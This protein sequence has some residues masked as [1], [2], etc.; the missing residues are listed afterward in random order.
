[1]IPE[2]PI[3]PIDTVDIG[4]H[5][6]E[7]P[8]RLQYPANLIH[9]IGKIL[10]SRQMFKKVAGEYDIQTFLPNTPVICRSLLNPLNTRFQAF[11]GGRIEVQCEFFGSLDIINKF[12][13]TTAEV[14]HPPTFRNIILKKW[15]INTC[16]TLFR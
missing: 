13:V 4:T 5:G 7:Q 8:S 15:G 3:G 11:P 10:L 6:D 14:Q 12:P 9:G 2:I 1:M 16:H